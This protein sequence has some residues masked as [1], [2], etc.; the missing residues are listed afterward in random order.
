MVN[1]NKLGV[2]GKFQ[3][4]RQKFQKQREKARDVKFAKIKAKTI[5]SS[6]APIKLPGVKVPARKRAARSLGVRFAI[7]TFRRARR[8]RGRVRLPTRAS[9]DTRLIKSRRIARFERVLTNPR[10]SPVSKRRFEKILE[11]LR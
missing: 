4:T 9:A 8:R 5:L 7:P 1:K 6:I 3:R 11:R 2:E 10:V